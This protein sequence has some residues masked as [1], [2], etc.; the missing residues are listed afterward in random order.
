MKRNYNTLTTA[1]DNKHWTTMMIIIITIMIIIIKK[2]SGVPHL[3]L[4]SKRFTIALE[5]S[6]LLHNNSNKNNKAH[7]G[8]QQK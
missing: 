4:G 1:T 7:E 8:T 6:D 3:V 2:I 5:Y